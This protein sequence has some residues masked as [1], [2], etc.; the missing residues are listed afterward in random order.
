MAA[1][2]LTNTPT[3]IMYMIFDRLPLSDLCRLRLACQW[4]EQ[5]SLKYFA[6]RAYKHINIYDHGG[7]LLRLARVLWENKALASSVET[8]Q[9]RWHSIKGR[10]KTEVWFPRHRYFADQPWK[11]SAVLAS[12]PGLKKLELYGMTDSPVLFGPYF[13]FRYS[14]AVKDVPGFWPRLDTLSIKSA[15]LPQPDLAAMLRILGPTLTTLH[16][17]DVECYR[18]RWVDT[19]RAAQRAAIGLKSLRL[20]ALWDD[21]WRR[22]KDSSVEYEGSPAEW[23]TLF[24]F[25]VEGAKLLTTFRGPNGIETLSLQRFDASMVGAK[26]IELGLDMIEEHVAVTQHTEDHEL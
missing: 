23:E 15:Y 8:L 6:L 2:L 21:I 13:D 1:S 14:S 12:V 4:A 3:D 10:P 18:G 5:Q 9:V 17:E 16:L 25:R 26:A 19:L 11:S 20:V 24:T 7:S 22:V